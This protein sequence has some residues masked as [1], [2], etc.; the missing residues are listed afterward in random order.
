MRET[1]TGNDH[2]PVRETPTK[3]PVRETPTTSISREESL[4]W[5]P[6]T[7]VA[8]GYEQRVQRRNGKVVALSMVRLPAAEPET[9]KGPVK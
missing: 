6:W 5:E 8:E 4:G 9:P 2:F 1:R 3:A 7:L